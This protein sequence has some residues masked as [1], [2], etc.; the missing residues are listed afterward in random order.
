MFSSYVAQVC[1]SAVNL[2]TLFCNGALYSNKL[3]TNVCTNLS[4][5]RAITMSNTNDKA[6][7]VLNKGRASKTSQHW[8]H[9]SLDDGEVLG[10]HWDSNSR[11]T[12]GETKKECV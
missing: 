1:C 9:N 6:E 5:F 12:K 3:A 11:R 2:E 7:E 4:S 10:A 8:S